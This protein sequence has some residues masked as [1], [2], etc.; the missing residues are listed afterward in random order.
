M[1]TPQS[2]D[3]NTGLTPKESVPKEKKKP[4]KKLF[5]IL[6]LVLIVLIGTGIAATFVLGSVGANAKVAT[7]F[8]NTFEEFT[9]ENHLLKDLDFGQICNSGEYSVDVNLDT[10]VSIIGDISFAFTSGVSKDAVS[11]NG[12]VNLS[13]I[14]PVEYDVYIDKDKVKGYTPFLPEYLFEYNYNESNNGYLAGY[15]NTSYI[16]TT[17][18]T[19]FDSLT[20][21]KS[22]EQR[23]KELKELLA[24][25]VSKIKFIKTA[26]KEFYINY[27]QTKCPGYV[28]EVSGDTITG[29]YDK[30]ERY[31]YE[32]GMEYL[33]DVFEKARPSKETTDMYV[34]LYNDRLMQVL[35]VQNDNPMLDIQFTG[36]DYRAQSLV[37]EVRNKPMF[38][39]KGGFEDGF[40][41]L[42][43]IFDQDDSIGYRY[44][45]EEGKFTLEVLN[46]GNSSSYYA[47]IKRTD[48]EIRIDVDYFDIG[49][50]YFGGRVSVYPGSEIKQINEKSE[51]SF[52]VGSATK[53]D[54]A[55]LKDYVYGLIMSLMGW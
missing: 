1:E 38:E 53:E 18:K 49:V 54:Y 36:R 17:I 23:S 46:K 22:S 26:K 40:E 34:Y 10:E 19:V 5:L 33:V 39:L 31:A 7:A 27:K 20:N 30:L 9:E 52:N 3:V 45:T 47:D 43:V 13:Y 35:L 37:I 51:K 21:I 29:I 2:F 41:E 32:N 16:N 25:D 28:A 6:A 24:E 11:I 4:G 55:V 50:S 48:D 15:F 14:P 42:T 8:V 12:N 44:D